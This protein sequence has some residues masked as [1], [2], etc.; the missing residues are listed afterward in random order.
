MNNNISL[1][2]YSHCS[3]EEERGRKGSDVGAEQVTER[4]RVNGYAWS[5]DESAEVF[6]VPERAQ[7]N[8]KGKDWKRTTRF[9]HVASH[10][11]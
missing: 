1:F 7:W 6:E 9:V 2:F 10:D 4:Q 3:T 11:L 8:S 5:E